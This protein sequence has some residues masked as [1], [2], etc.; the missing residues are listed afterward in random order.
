M[1]STQDSESCDPSSNLGGTWTIFLKME[2]IVSYQQQEQY[3]YYRKEKKENWFLGILM[4]PIDSSALN[5]WL[6]CL[7][8]LLVKH[9]HQLQISD[10]QDY[11]WG[12]P[13]DHVQVWRPFSI[14]QFWQVCFQLWGEQVNLPEN[15]LL[16]FN[17][18]KVF[19]PAAFNFTLINFYQEN[20]TQFLCQI[21]VTRLLLLS[22]SWPW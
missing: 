21:S 1:V 10:H 19:R 3:Q 6:T 7:H 9:F 13:L 15:Y 20:W 2:N 5:S 16:I 4:W 11:Y 14:I 12:V 18:C 8:R 22:S 17:T